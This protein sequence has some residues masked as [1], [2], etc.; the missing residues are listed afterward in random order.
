MARNYNNIALAYA[1]RYGIITYKLK[2]KIMEYN[3]NYKNNEFI[4]GAWR[5]KCFTIKRFINLETGDIASKRLSRLVA[6][7]WDNV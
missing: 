6:D 7:G 2:G 3:Q 4:N 1:E 5:S